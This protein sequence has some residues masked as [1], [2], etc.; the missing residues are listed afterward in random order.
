VKRLVLG[1]L[2]AATVLAAPGASA[3]TR[4]EVLVRARAYAAHRWSSTSANQTASCSSKYKSLFPAGDYVGLPYGWGGYMTLRT[5]DQLIASGY[6][7]GS[8]ET[9]GVLDCIAGVDCSGFVSM[10]WGAPHNT[11]SSIPGVTSSIAKGDMLPGDVFNKA[12]YH[13]AMFTSL[14]QSGEPALIESVAYGVH[15]NSYGGWSYVNGYSPRRYPALTGTTAGNPVGTTSNPISI[16]GFP[17]SDSRDTRSSSSSVLDACGAAP[18]TPQKGPEYVYVANITQPGTLTIS[19]QDDA[20]TDVDVQLLDNLSTAACIARSDST[21]SAQVGCGT[22]WVVVDTYGSDASKAGPYTLNVSLAPSGQ[23][24]SA[25]QGPPAFNP[26]GKLG[27][28]CSYPAN[29]SLPFCNPNVGSETCIYSSQTSF[30]SKSCATNAD[31]VD[32]GAGACCADIGSGELYCLTSSFCGG[33]VP[34]KADG[35]LASSSGGPASSSS[36][37]GETSSSGSTSGGSTSGGEEETSGDDDDPG[38]APGGGVTTKSVSGCNAAPSNGASA[39]ALVA[40]AAML[41]AV[42]RRRRY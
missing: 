14:L 9:D 42:V 10:A 7:A 24:C 5:F 22:Y 11:T 15:P 37:G 23:A 36:S 28:A 38:A 31:C 29:P 16:G 33:G 3:L 41:G 4:E 40:A 18:G 20:A 32:L 21:I 17:F 30:C 34:P 1:S 27:E 8:Q 13:V 2:F 25:V 19:V 12:G 6:G 26:K 35:G 39:I